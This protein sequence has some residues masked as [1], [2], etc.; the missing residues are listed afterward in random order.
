MTWYQ[1]KLFVLNGF[2][3]AGTTS[4]HTASFGP[5]YVLK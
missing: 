1:W 5:K 4:H 2:G 3:Y